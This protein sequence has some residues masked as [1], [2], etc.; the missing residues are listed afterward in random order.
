MHCASSISDASLQIIINKKFPLQ[1][2]CA[3]TQ[4]GTEATEAVNVNYGNDLLVESAFEGRS[5]KREAV[6]ECER[7]RARV[8]CSHVVLAWDSWLDAH[9]NFDSSRAVLGEIVGTRLRGGSSLL[10][11]SLL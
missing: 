4:S 8:L 1:S 2:N 6:P 5:S 3:H 11:Q 7:E 9:R 10:A